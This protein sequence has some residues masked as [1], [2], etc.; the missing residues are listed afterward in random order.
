MD[1]IPASKAS[2]PGAEAPVEELIEKIHDTVDTYA[3]GG[4]FYTSIMEQDPERIWIALSELYAYG[5]EF[6][7][8]E[9]LTQPLKKQKA[10][11]EKMNAQ[12]TMAFKVRES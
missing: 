11:S 8:N 3:S 5:R 10:Q 6:Y 4:G 9:R 7:D 1:L 12:I 2:W